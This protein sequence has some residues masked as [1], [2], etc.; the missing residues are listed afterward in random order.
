VAT[1][2]SAILGT[3]HF[4]DAG[5]AGDPADAWNAAAPSYGYGMDNNPASAV[6]PANCNDTGDGVEM[7]ANAFGSDT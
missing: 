4:A 3:V 1:G 5:L 2:P 7:P 6:P